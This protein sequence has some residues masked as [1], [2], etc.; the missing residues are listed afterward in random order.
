M[1][2][3]LLFSE[4]LNMPF[5]NKGI[6]KNLNDLFILGAELLHF[7]KLL[8]QFPVGQLRRYGCIV[9][10]IIHQLIG[11][12]VQSFGQ[13]GKHICCGFGLAY[14]IAANLH[15]RVQAYDF[16]QAPPVSVFFG[17]VTL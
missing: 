15:I 11:S 14:F 1:R 13:P 16:R 6:D 3:A 9:H 5:S 8:Q 12:C 17:H 10:V 4:F 7:L 2:W